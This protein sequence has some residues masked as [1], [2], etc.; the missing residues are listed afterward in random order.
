MVVVESRLLVLMM[1]LVLL[2]VVVLILSLL[3]KYIW[4]RERNMMNSRE[5]RVDAREYIS[6]Y[7]FSFYP[8][9]YRLID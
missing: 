1:M 5:S 6:R 3:Y 9:M 8:R 2:L 4:F 7:F